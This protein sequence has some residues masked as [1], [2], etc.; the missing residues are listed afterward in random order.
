MTRD[1]LIDLF[2]RLRRYARLLTG[3]EAGAD[4]LVQETLVRGWEKRA[5]FQAGSDLRAWLFS[6]MHNLNV[7]RWRAAGRD[8]V[9]AAMALDDLGDAGP[10]GPALG[11][12]QGL[13][14]GAASPAGVDEMI[15]LQR[16]LRQLP[17]DQRAVL[18]LVC[19]EQCSYAEV[20]GM[21][22]VPIGTVMSRLSRARS[23]LR[24]WLDDGRPALRL[25]DAARGGRTRRGVNE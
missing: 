7:G 23:A 5:Q 19:V 11:P 16:G 8:P 9:H 6:I 15:D 21:L 24:D 22:G 13:G 20:A 4:D 2:P 18:L 14:Q 17:D 25:V 1:D 12:R 10:A 3:N